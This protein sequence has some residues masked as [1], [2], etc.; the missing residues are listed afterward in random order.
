MD[1]TSSS[2]E[3]SGERM[4]QK[5]STR[6]LS[7]AGR[8]SKATPRSSR[9]SS[10]TSGKRSD[11]TPTSGGGLEKEREKE[12]GERTGRRLSVAGWAS[13]A[14]GSVTG[15]G[16]K[17]KDNFAA[18]IGS[19][20]NG[21][22]DGESEE[23]PSASTSQ[24]FPSFTSKKTDKKKSKESLGHPSPKPSARIL[25][26]LSLQDKKCV[27]ALHDFT[28]TSDE[29][30]FKA[31]DEIVVINE[32]LDEWWMGELDGRKGLFPT[33]YTETITSSASDDAQEYG[34]SDI[35]DDHLFRADHLTPAQS[36][37]YGHSDVAS[38]TSS[39]AEDEGEIQITVDAPR[40]Q[41]RSD[42]GFF[43]SSTPPLTRQIL[44]DNTP[45]HSSS[46]GKKP[47]PPP[48]PRRL[49]TNGSAN[50]P[51]IPD[52]RPSALRSVSSP[53]GPVLTPSSSSTSSNQDYDT[54]PFE[55]ATDFIRTGCN[56]FRQNP[57]KP[58]GMCSNCFTSHL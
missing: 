37:F 20:E 30:S 38:I 22:S 18:L 5:G 47:P 43:T 34:E 57:F 15:L 50:S 46:L 58:K 29:L 45:P 13:T 28:G 8:K 17:N 53:A 55:S 21:E 27:R 31:G 11:G 10:R 14:V 19:G 12:R 7:S 25:K 39:A 40:S 48:P 4:S 54:S 23:F 51:V 33:S 44:T 2:E 24:S 56:D 9:P 36:Q 32:V 3:S 26:P 52:R 42:T 41:S 35:E 1:E 16:K 6:R 49:T